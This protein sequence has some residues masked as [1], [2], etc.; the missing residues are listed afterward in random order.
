M[1]CGNEGGR[2]HPRWEQ[3]VE[4]R[5]LHLHRGQPDRC[6]GRTSCFYP[7]NPETAHPYGVSLLRTFRSSRKR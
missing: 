4:F 7:L 2:V 5:D 6:R 1:V 3:S